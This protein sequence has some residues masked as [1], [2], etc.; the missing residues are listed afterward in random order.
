MKGIK[1]EE[2]ITRIITIF[3]SPA[4]YAE[5]FKTYVKVP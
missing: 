4:F 1:A 2:A 3:Q 5:V